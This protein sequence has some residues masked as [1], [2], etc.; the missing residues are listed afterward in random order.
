MRVDR[1]NPPSL[2]ATPGYHHVTIV[3]AGPTVHLAGQCPLDR[4]G[5][6]VAPADTAD[7]SAVTAQVEQVVANSLAA[8]AAGGAGP[9]DVVRSVV[10]VATDDRALL[11]LAWRLFTE[12]AL[13]PAFTSASTLLGVS[14]LRFP[15]Q[16]VELDLTAAPELT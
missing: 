15:G 7:A 8:L 12:S 14:R 2:H 16:V 10:Y 3:A 11:S 4:S 5:A 1:V 9:A 6:V 13:G